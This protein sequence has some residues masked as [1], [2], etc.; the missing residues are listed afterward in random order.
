MPDFLICWRKKVWLL[1]G[2]T[3]QQLIPQRTECS[4]IEENKELN[5][6][7]AF[8]PSFKVSK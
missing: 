6:H 2:S 4:N 7:D 5:G 8:L 1:S 3:K